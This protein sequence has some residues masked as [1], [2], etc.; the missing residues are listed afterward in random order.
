MVGGLLCLALGTMYSV[1]KVTTSTDPKFSASSE[2][3]DSAGCNFYVAE[4][5][6]VMEQ[7]GE[8]DRIPRA[9]PFENFR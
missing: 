3:V 6:V 5:F 9:E 4:L 8:A 1:G 2:R 7:P